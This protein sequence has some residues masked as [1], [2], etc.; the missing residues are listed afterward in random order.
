[1]PLTELLIRQAKGK[2]KTY[3]MSDGKGLGMEVRPDGKK[4]WIIRYWE[5]KKER[6]KSA[7]PYPEVSLKAA[8]E[9]NFFFR[10][11]W[12]DGKLARVK[13]ENFSDIAEEWYT[14]RIA[15]VCGKG[16]MKHVRSRLDKMILP[17]I[18]EMKLS[19]IKAPKVLELCQKQEAK[20]N[21]ETGRI[22]KQIVSQVFNYGIATGRTELNPTLGLKGA[23]QRIKR[24]HYAAITEPEKIGILMRQIEAY[25]YKIVGYALQLSALTF[26]RPGEIRGALWS[27]I[28]WDKK[29]WVIG[30]ERM[31]MRRIHIV[32]LA[33]QTL[34]L[35]QK[36]HGLTGEQ[37]WLFP[38]ARNTERCLSDNATRLALR[39]IGYTTEEMTPHGFRAMASTTLYNN[40]F[41]K[42][43][44]E[45]QLAHAD[46]NAIR[47]AY[48]HAEYLPQ[49][50][51]MM[52]WYADYLDELKK[53]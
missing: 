11:D 25:P 32:P 52:Q 41:T 34:E 3:I 37:K 47:A 42:D 31:K 23:L 10:K 7:G 46:K 44:V 45:M 4:Y 36:L 13:E 15:S 27:E 35:I 24:S 51:E 53:N 2:E 43:H 1:M 39:A 18:G 9:R 5:N 40:G 48:N 14:K 28:E 50:R 49:R 20:G 12:E 19:Q 30:G 33:C 29:Q 8:R 17:F 16:Y 22:V 21:I 38:S 6:R 26:C